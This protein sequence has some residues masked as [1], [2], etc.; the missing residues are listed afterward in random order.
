MRQSSGY[1]LLTIHLFN[2]ISFTKLF[3]NKKPN[4]EADI[5]L[6]RYTNQTLFVF[7]SSYFIKHEI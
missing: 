7:R 4:V 3:I 6:K 5:Y 2:A 1:H